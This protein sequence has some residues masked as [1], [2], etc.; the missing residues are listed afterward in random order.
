MLHKGPPQREHWPLIFKN[1]GLATL[2]STAP[3][4]RRVLPVATRERPLQAPAAA[5][6]REEVAAVVRAV[7]DRHH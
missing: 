5:T 1:P 3:V 2:G 6:D 7:V 4:L